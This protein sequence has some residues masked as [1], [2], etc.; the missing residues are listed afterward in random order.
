[1]ILIPTCVRIRNDVKQFK[2]SHIEI[3]GDLIACEKNPNFKHF[4]LNV[5]GVRDVPSLV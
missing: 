5:G 2:Y 3:L 1:M 4:S